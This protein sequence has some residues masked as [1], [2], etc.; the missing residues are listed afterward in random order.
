M[1]HT[2]TAVNWLHLENEFLNSLKGGQGRVV[3]ECSLRGFTA[4]QRSLMQRLPTLTTVLQYLCVGAG[5]C[6]SGLWLP[7]ILVHSS[8]DHSWL[9][10]KG[11]LV[12]GMYVMSVLTFAQW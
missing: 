7:S 6:G 2:H 11:I 9:P 8:N 4:T 3:T 12:N 1:T 10:P 5:H